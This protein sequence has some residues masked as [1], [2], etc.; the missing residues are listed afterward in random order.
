MKQTDNSPRVLTGV[1]GVR[2]SEDGASCP[3]G[4]R[5]LIRVHVLDSGLVHA[6]GN[7]FG[8]VNDSGMMIIV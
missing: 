1:S 5:H 6:F 3:L 8:L 2:W 4:G 7:N